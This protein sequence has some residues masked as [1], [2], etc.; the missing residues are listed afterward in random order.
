[1]SGIKAKAIVD[2][3]TGRFI[4]GNP[5][6]AA[7]RKGAGDKTNNY[8]TKKQRAMIRDMMD[9]KFDTEVEVLNGDGTVV[10]RTW[11]DILGDMLVQM[12][13]MGQ[14]T[15]PTIR[16]EDGQLIPGRTVTS[17]DDDWMKN[18]LR[19]WRQWQPPDITIKHEDSVLISFDLGV[20]NKTY[21]QLMAEADENAERN[22]IDFNS[23][24]KQLTDGDGRS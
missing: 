19:F 16:L 9:M 5:G 22:I 4:V 24:P 2:P 14:A 3:S 8:E 7:L 13:V 6:G 20:S 18:A 23:E 1:M 17:R 11:M 12:S 10:T 21:Q 15:Y